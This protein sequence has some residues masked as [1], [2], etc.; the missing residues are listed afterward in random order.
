VLDLGCQP[1][2]NG[3]RR[4]VSDVVPAFPLVICRCR[5]CGTI[6]LT[7]TV[8]PEV[9]F[10][11]YVWV[12]GTSE[13]ARAYSG[14]FCERLLERSGPGPRFVIEV[15]SNDGTFL[16]RFA[17]RGHRVLGVD[18]AVNIARLAERDGVPTIAEFFGL[19]VS[20]QI[21]AREGQ[22]DIVFARNVLPHVADANDVV[23]GMA[24]CL[25][26]DGIGAIEFH[27]ADII[28]DE[29][30]YDS[31]YHEHLV[32]HSLHSLARLLERGGLQPF[33]ASTSPISGGSLVVYV[34]KQSRPCTERYQR[35]IA[36]ERQLG[37]GELEPWR[38][39]ANRAR[40][41]AASLKALVA[42]R[43]A[44]GLRVIGYGASARSS[45]L[46]N[47]CGID[48]TE[49]EAIADR[50]PLKHNTYAPGTNIPIVSPAAAFETRPDVVL[51]LAWNF[52][53]EILA[54]MRQEFGW[55]GEVIVPLP[56]QPVVVS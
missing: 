50:A 30:H 1:L 33:D 54:Q 55:H 4:R 42:D 15:A 9:L 27:R 31:I 46:L 11:E 14:E 37:I 29:L 26:P 22:A 16:R 5:D 40:E 21:V 35:L 43:R 23:A 41:H 24:H 32:Y 3:L 25:R 8:A 2:A 7:E 38:A 52:R 10:R 47:F 13:G 12:T 28:L 6:Q 56:N 17:E 34:S 44:R 39:F 20:K 18:P 53:D 45:T 36:Q 49:L 48:S 51:L 19:E